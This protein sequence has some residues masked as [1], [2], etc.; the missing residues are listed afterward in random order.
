M[1]DTVKWNEVRQKFSQLVPQ[2]TADV[3]FASLSVVENRQEKIIEISADRL[4]MYYL[5]LNDFRF[6][7]IL[8]ETI[9]KTIGQGSRKWDLW[10]FE[11]VDKAID[12][13]KKAEYIKRTDRLSKTGLN[14]FLTFENYFS[15]NDNFLVVQSCHEIIKNLNDPMR[16][17]NSFFIYGLS[18]YGKTHISNALGNE[19]F[20]RYDDLKVLYCTGQG[21]VSDYVN[22]FKSD[23][24]NI[25]SF[26]N[27]YRTVDVLIVDDF[28]WM[29][30]KDNSL[31]TFFNIY[32]DMLNSNK[33]VV[34]CSDTSL[35]QLILPNRMVTRI[36]NGIMVEMNK[37][38]FDTR[39]QIFNYHAA[40]FLAGI[41]FEK[42]AVDIICQNFNNPRELIGFI[43]NLNMFLIAYKSDVVT[44]DMANDFLNKMVMSSKLR[45]A[46]IIDIVCNHFGYKPEEVLKTGTRGKKRIAGDFIIYFLV[47][48]LK[49]NQKEVARIFNFSDHSSVSKRCSLF[50]KEEKQQYSEDFRNLNKK[51]TSDNVN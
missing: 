3:I 29:V 13:K 11:L 14:H 5:K 34:F 1:L 31:D 42:E 10:S 48:K 6:F 50:E 37:P 16:I 35:D 19:I 17:T 20:A 18:G 7:N 39:I 33:L 15:S 2:D 41:R 38:D 8:V 30:E 4:S 23:A 49:M 36:R 47:K 24:D 43:R 21:F 27:K 40:H 22:S 9:K 45:K 46:D 26:Y 12:D 51:I 28:Q 32:D 25:N 44:E